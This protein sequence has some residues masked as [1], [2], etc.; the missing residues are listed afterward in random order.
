MGDL[1]SVR[2]LGQ[3]LPISPYGGG[4]WV[5]AS[6]F[7]SHCIECQPRWSGAHY[8]VEETEVSRAVRHHLKIPCYREGG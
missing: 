5:S 6:H 7:Q 1:G 8:T 2:E 3:E 4:G